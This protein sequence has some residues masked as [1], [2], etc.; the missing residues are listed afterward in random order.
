MILEIFD[1][2]KQAFVAPP[3]DPSV[4]TLRLPNDAMPTR[5][6]TKTPTK[7]VDDNVFY[8]KASQAF[9]RRTADTASQSVAWEVVKTVDVADT[10]KTRVGDITD[11]DRQELADRNLETDKALIIKPYWVKK[12][13]RQDAAK[14]IG[15]K[16]IYQSLIGQYYAAFSAANGEIEQ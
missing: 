5:T 9:V 2:I 13:G 12:V 8:S 11:N 16:G 1:A 7:K 14:M 3:F 10:T 4:S 15:Q 6:P